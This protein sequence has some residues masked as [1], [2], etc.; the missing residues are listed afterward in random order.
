MFVIKGVSRSGHQLGLADERSGLVRHIYRLLDETQA[1]DT[2][3]VHTRPSHKS[4]IF[5][6]DE[7]TKVVL[8]FGERQ[9]TPLSQ[10]APNA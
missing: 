7:K 6:W 9:F 5:Q 3:N 1:L 2:Q 8:L 4:P 10:T